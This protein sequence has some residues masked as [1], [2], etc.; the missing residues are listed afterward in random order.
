MSGLSLYDLVIPT[1]TKGLKTFDHVLIKAEEY[2]KKNGIDADAEFPE[3]RLVA[4]QLPLTFQVQN[5]TKNVATTL[6]RLTGTEAA[7]FDN[8]EKTIA[9]LHA[10]IQATLALLEKVDPAV[11]NSREDAEIDM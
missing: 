5:V 11:V 3:A 8:K 7:T 10:R 9:D 4:D 2:A 6:S 1:F